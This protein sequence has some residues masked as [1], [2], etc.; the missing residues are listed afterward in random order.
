MKYLGLPWR[1]ALWRHVP[2]PTNYSAGSVSPA[3]EPEEEAM[4]FVALLIET[5]V[6]V[7][8]ASALAVWSQ[9]RFAPRAQVA[10]ATR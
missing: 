8:V 7:T 6:A 5:G 9:K 4:V 3:R 1:Y 10:E 2:P